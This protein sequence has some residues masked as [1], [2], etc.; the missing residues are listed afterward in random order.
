MNQLIDPNVEAN[1]QRIAQMMMQNQNPMAI[2]IPE[3]P[4]VQS[5]N[6]GGGGMMDL[7]NLMMMQQMRQKAAE[8]PP[9]TAFPEIASLPVNR[10]TDTRQGG[11]GGFPIDR[12]PI[13]N[14]SFPKLPP[15]IPVSNSNPGITTR[16]A[17]L[18]RGK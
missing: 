11:R 17:S 9:A 3:D 8:V 13:Q 18:L 12:N 14:S 16:L 10:G 15:E 1:R 4:S 2:N 7:G 5:A 6:S